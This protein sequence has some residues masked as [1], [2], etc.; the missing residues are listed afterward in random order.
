MKRCVFGDRFR[1]MRVDGRP[2]Q[3]EKISVFKQK[4]I[5]V[6]GASDFQVFALIIPTCLRVALLCFSVF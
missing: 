3:E 2:D 6:E 4:R 1:R 5:R